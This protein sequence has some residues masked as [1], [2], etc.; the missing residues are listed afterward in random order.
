MF[1]GCGAGVRDRRCSKPECGQSHPCHQTQYCFGHAIQR[2]SPPFY[3]YLST[4]A[5][6]ANFY[7]LRFDRTIW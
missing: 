4:L 1:V 2:G 7:L 5:E 6:V 3:Q